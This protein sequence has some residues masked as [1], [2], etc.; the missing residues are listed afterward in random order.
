VTFQVADLG[1]WA[2][3]CP[4]QELSQSP[5]N[6]SGSLTWLTHTPTHSFS[7]VGFGQALTINRRDI[8]KHQ[9]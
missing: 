2:P 1:C 8:S 9:N 4:A 6:A 5:I 7:K 3:A